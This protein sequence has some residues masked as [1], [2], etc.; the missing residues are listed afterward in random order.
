MPENFVYK[1]GVPVSMESAQRGKGH[2]VGL[3]RHK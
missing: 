1:Q 3:D 2:E